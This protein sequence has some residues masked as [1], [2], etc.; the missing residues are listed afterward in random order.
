MKKEI[1]ISAVISAVILI[2]AVIICI[3]FIING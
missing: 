3:N 2:G 1:I